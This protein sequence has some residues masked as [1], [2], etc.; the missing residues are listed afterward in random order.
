MNKYAK[1]PQPRHSEPLSK[2]CIWCWAEKVGSGIGIDGDWVSFACAPILV[3]DMGLS[4]SER[5]LGR[6]NNLY[7]DGICTRTS[8]DVE[9]ICRDIVAEFASTKCDHRNTTV[10]ADICKD[11]CTGKRGIE[12]GILPPEIVFR[13]SILDSGL[14]NPVTKAGREINN[15]LT[16][17]N[18]RNKHE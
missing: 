2:R 1:I 18:I 3:K 16:N 5:K 8:A 15:L 12:T 13:R 9:I 7:Q 4:W 10:I 11:C 14:D 17:M 6:I